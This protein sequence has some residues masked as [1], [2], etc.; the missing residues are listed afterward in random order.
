MKRMSKLSAIIMILIFLGSLV[1]FGQPMNVLFIVSDDLNS[2]LGVYGSERAVTPHLNRLAE[3]GM[4]FTSAHAQYPVCNPSRNSFLSGMRPNETGLPMGWEALRKLVSDVTTLPQ[5]FRENGYY[6]ASIGKIFHISNWDSRWPNKGGWRLG[7]S[8]SWDFRV[9][10]L[11]ANQGKS[12]VPPFP[13]KG[14]KLTWPG[15]SGAIDYGMISYEDDLMH[16]DGQATQEAIRQLDL[17]K[18]K[19]F[20]LAVGYRRPHAP[21][22]APEKYFSPY[23]LNT[24]QLPDPGDRSDVTK[25]AFTVHPPNYG[26]PEEMKKM[27][28]SYLAS[29]S[30]LDSQVGRLLQSL[31]DH[32]LMDNTIIVF[33]SDHG[34]HLGE[35]GQWHKFTLYEESTQVPLLIRVPGMTKPGSV[36]DQIVELVD[37]FP[38]LQELCGMP[39]Q[40][41]KLAGQSL[42]PLLKNSP[43]SWKE[44]PAVTQVRRGKDEKAVMG[45]SLRTK[46]Y[47]YNEWWTET[48]NP[49]LVA[50]ELYDLQND[51]EEEFNRTDNTNY[52]EVRE[53]L[54]LMLADYRKP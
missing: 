14:E 7:D 4:Q 49:E 30:F 29:V 12:R 34:F 27:K 3:M 50:S 11:P 37:L 46:D 42:M 21:F 1:T 45:Y 52:K 16:E 48:E 6:T 22:V 17:N 39:E 33:F 54:S 24:M 43:D 44:K 19:P 53:K 23:P 15:H 51:P 9:N 8:L 38:T 40:N 36:S 5:L 18:D 35:H 20:F 31:E 47:R 32:N 10:C 26:E 28:M 2:E 41:Q 13:R 25:L